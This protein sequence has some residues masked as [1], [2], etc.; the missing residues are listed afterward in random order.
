MDCV[1]NIKMLVEKVTTAAHRTISHVAGL[2][3]I[4]ISAITRR[5]IPEMLD[6]VIALEQVWNKRIPTA[7]LNAW[8][9]EFT[10]K[11]PPP[12]SAM[13]RS[14]LKYITQTNSRPPSFVVFCTRAESISESYTRFLSKQ[15]R[16]SFG[17]DG[18]PLRIKLRKQDN[19]YAK[20]ARR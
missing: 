7:Q 14:K 8:L 4:P 12:A 1:S 3:I 13:Y 11:N 17:L 16:L 5:G 15:L 9:R 18:I 2:S 20:T 19:P 10:A 6:S